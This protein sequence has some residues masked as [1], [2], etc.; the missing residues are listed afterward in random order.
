M[1]R[2]VDVAFTGDHLAPAGVAVVIDVLRATTTATAALRGGYGVVHV[3]ASRD[4]ARRLRGPGRVLAGEE[5]G[6]RPPDFDL[7]NSPREMEPARGDELVLATTN[8][9]PAVVAAADMAPT[10]LLGCLWNLDAV[11]A[12]LRAADVDRVLVVCSG[13]DGG[14]AVE[15]VFVAGLIVRALRAA[16]AH[17]GDSALVAQDVAR[18]S[19]SV[20]EAL[21]RGS[22]AAVLVAAGLVADIDDCARV[23]ITDVVGV[24]DSCR[25]GVARVVRAAPPA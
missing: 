19:T 15:D 1:A 9:A 6:L 2:R 3:A 25:D 24:V 22:N 5:R 10:V 8:G 20:R 21:A 18:A 17:A 7:G 11:L 13:T 4:A 12:H 16:G 14:V 23:S